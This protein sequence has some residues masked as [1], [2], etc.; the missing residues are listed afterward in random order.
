MR[1]LTCIV[2]T[3]AALAPCRPASAQP[4]NLPPPGPAAT[5]LWTT[6]GTAVGTPVHDDDSIY[7]LSKTHEV[8]A[9]AAIDGAVRWRTATGARPHDEV[10]GAITA[11]SALALTGD[12]VIAGDWDVVAFDRRSGTRRWL[13]EAQ[14]GDGPGLFLGPVSGNTVVTGSPAGRVYAIDVDSG[15]QRWMTSIVEPRGVLTSVFP[16]VLNGHTLIVAYSTYDLPGTGGVAALEAS[17]G[18]LHWRTAFPRAREPW[19]SASRSGG[20]VVAGDRVWVS[21]SDGNIYAYDLATGERRETLPRLEGPF[22][23]PISSSDID[24]RAITRSGGLLIAGSAT[25]AVVAYD[26]ETLAIRWRYEAGLWGSTTF[27]LA[28]DEA[29]AY[30]PFFGGF[31]VALDLADGRELW[32]FGDFNQGFIWAPAVGNGRLFACGSRAGLFAVSTSTPEA[33][34]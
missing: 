25:G 18:R 31:I 16:P 8:V 19:Q 6:S 13:F 29:R 20:P 33:P 1:L 21:V 2:M 10:F 4:T 14:E 15:R 27:S 7:F 12:L 17:T 26:L 9:A 11:G 28:A 23:G 3:T 32:R 34:R 30:V 22:L 24:Q 5:V